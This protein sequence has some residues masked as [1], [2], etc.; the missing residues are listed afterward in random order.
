M[1]RPPSHTSF[2]E[3]HSP[4]VPLWDVIV[5]DES[6]RAKNPRTKLYA[7]L[8]RL[9]ARSRLLVTGTPVQNNLLELHALFDLACPGLLG[10]RKHFNRRFA[11]AIEASQAC[12]SRCVPSSQIHVVALLQDML[13][14]FWHVP[15]WHMSS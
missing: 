7:A 11:G 15:P 14:T 9:Q 10:D 12:P 1:R 4:G 8:Q 2:P 6:H 13:Q 3:D 5:L